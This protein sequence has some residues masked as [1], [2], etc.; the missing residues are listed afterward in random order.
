MYQWYSSAKVCYVY[1]QDVG[2][3]GYDA[4]VGS[5][6]EFSKSRWFTRGWTPQE[7]L[8][9]V[10]LQFYSR[11]WTILEEL[12][13]SWYLA[14]VPDGIP[15]LMGKIAAITKIDWRGLAVVTGV[16]TVS[17]AMRMSW[18]SRRNT[19]RPEDM[20]YCLMGLFKVHMPIIYGE[21]KTEALQTAAA[22]SLEIRRPFNP[23]PAAVSR[24]RCPVSP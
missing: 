12:E 1:L 19:T 24:R 13:K 20:A 9:P 16:R 8:A 5:G 2:Q 3:H 23:C 14:R 22:N 11:D 17:A 4:S 10:W 18:A 15:R 6:D 21:G 7:L